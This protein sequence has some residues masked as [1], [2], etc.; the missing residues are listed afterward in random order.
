MKFK[1]CTKTIAL[2]VFALIGRAAAAAPGDEEFKQHYEHGLHAYNSEQYDD[3]IKEFEA[4]YAIKPKPRLLF[5][6]GQAFRILGNAREALRFYLL[7]QALEPNPKPG[8][9]AELEGYIAQLRDNIKQAQAAQHAEERAQSAAPAIARPQLDLMP[10]ADTPGL[11]ISRAPLA[12]PGRAPVYKRAWF[13]IG[14]AGAAA[15]I[16]ISVGVGVGVGQSG[17]HGDVRNLFFGGNP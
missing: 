13:W 4:A 6:I 14:L 9:K 7:Y 8:L 11:A 1:L 10:R 15:V 3:A 12:S 5:N 16:A 2:L 17:Y